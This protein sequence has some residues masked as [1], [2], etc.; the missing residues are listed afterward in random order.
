M[1]SQQK[2][3]F[4]IHASHPAIAYRNNPDPY[5]TSDE[6]ISAET[7]TLEENKVETKTTTTSQSGRSHI[8]ATAMRMHDSGEIA[9]IH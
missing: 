4:A 9:D 2:M 1:F 5:A 7:Q 8:P 3:S 6:P